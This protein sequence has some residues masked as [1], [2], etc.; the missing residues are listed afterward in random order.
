MCMELYHGDEDYIEAY[1]R[2]TIEMAWKASPD[3]DHDLYENMC[4]VSESSKINNDP[5]WV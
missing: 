1:E 3:D 5:A 2:E 4:Y